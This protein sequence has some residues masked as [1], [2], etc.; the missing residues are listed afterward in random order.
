MNTLD[1]LLSADRAKMETPTGE[2][3]IT[4]LSKSLG[5]PVIFKYRALTPDEDAEIRKEG[6]KFNSKGEFEDLDSS[7]M[8]CYQ[9]LHGVI[10]PSFKSD[11]LS[12]KFGG[13]SPID[14]IKAILLPGEISAL[15][16][17]IQDLSGFGEGAVEDLKNE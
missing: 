15:A 5:K 1:L 12:K 8:Q 9:I 11:E 14:T 2:K 4:R 6:I 13:G 10:D 7:E 16:T 17:A 3:N